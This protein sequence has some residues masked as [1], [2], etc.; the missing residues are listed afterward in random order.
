MGD[1][2]GPAVAEGVYRE[3]L[4]RKEITLDDIPYALDAAVRRLRDSGVPASR[5]AT[6]IHLGG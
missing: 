3:I 6:F 1:V 4:S 5:W 2:D